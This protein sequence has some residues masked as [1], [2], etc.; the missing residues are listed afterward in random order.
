MTKQMCWLPRLGGSQEKILHLRT[1][2]HGPWRPYTSLPQF[3][4]PDY[5]VPGGSK[6]WAT[7]QKLMKAGWTLLPS[8]VELDVVDS[9]SSPST[10]K[11]AV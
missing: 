9:G 2:S 4:A 1:E 6:G 11:R 3:A 10:F 8:P 5:Q 7:Y